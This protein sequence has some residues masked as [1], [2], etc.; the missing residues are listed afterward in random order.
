MRPVSRVTALIVLIL[1]AFAVEPALA[2]KA[3]NAA[4]D[5]TASSASSDS[6]PSGWQKIADN[7][8]KF[9]HWGF[10]TRLFIGLGLA[11]ACSWLIAWHPR[12]STKVDPLSDLEERKA[13]ILLGLVGAVAAEIGID[14]NMAF[15]IF[16]IGALVRFRTVLQ[17]P[18]VTGKAILVVIIGL[19]CGAGQ[20]AMATFVTA[21]AWGLIFW[22]DSHISARIRLRLSPK[23]DIKHVYGD[24][25]EF[26]QRNHC[27]IKSTALYEAKRQITILAHIPA[28]LDPVELEASL[29]AKLPKAADGCEVDIRV[30]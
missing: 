22:L 2:D 8:S 25:Q 18:K 17:N 6:S 13:L 5:L 14:Q 9:Y 16:G 26:L 12:R 19:A 21:A 4:A 29:K 20:W 23:L 30:A 11:V 1:L 27:R 28:D 15:V 10:I 3:T 24:V 7:A